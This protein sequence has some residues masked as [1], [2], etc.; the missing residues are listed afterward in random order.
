[1]NHVMYKHMEREEVAVNDLVLDK[2][3]DICSKGPQKSEIGDEDLIIV[4]RVCVVRFPIREVK[5]GRY[6]DMAAHSAIQFCSFRAIM[7]NV[8]RGRLVEERSCL[9]NTDAC[10]FLLRPR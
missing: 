5:I 6:L 1:M 7:A 9:L 3:I 4:V 2:Y 10:T 8:E